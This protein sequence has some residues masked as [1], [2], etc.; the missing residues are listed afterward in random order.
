MAED[1]NLKKQ[2]ARLNHAYNLECEMVRAIAAF[3]HAAIRPLFLLNGGALVAYL[4]LYGALN[5]STSA[6]QFDKSYTIL[7]MALWVLGL[8]FAAICTFTAAKSQFSFREVR[9]L[10]VIQAEI[11]VGLPPTE[12]KPPD[13]KHEIGR[14]GQQ[15]ECW[16]WAA[17]VLGVISLMLFMGA[18]IP[19]FLSFNF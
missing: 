19:A 17:V 3:E 5:R 1:D 9:G 10:K 4:A 14:R 15:A 16:R 7:A 12:E 11:E 6:T 8:V 13:V 18:A 2:L